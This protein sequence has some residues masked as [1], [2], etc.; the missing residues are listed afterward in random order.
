VKS[1]LPHTLIRRWVNT[2]ENPVSG[3]MLVGVGMATTLLLCAGLLVLALHIVANVSGDESGVGGIM[4]FMIIPLVGLA[5]A[6]WSVLGVRD[7]NGSLFLL[8]IVL[9][10][11][12]NGA[13]IGAVF[14]Y[15]AARR[16]NRERP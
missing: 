11:L 5:G 7:G 1:V 4:G 12:I 16:M 6:P 13:L 10:P 3:Y 9:G 15:I 14:G 8:W 2:V